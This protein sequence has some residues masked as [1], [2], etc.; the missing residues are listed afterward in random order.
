MMGITEILMVAKFAV[1]HGFD[2]VEQITKACGTDEI[3]KEL[4][5]EQ[6]ARWEK[7]PDDYL[8]EAEE[9]AKG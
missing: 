2:A 6:A 1:T 3:T 8:R 9:R 7:S 4:W 5:E